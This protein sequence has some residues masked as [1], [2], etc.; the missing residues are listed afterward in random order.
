MVP[1]LF[2]H[3][4][5]EWTVVSGAP[6]SFGIAMLLGAAAIAWG[7]RWQ[8]SGRQNSYD[9]EAR[10][11]RATIT[12]LQASND[13]LSRKLADAEK[14]PGG[15]PVSA[16]SLKIPREPDG[17]YQFGRR[18]G[19]ASGAEIQ[20]GAGKAFFTRIRSQGNFNN[21]ND[22]EYRDFILRILSSQ[23]KTNAMA[24]GFSY[25]QIL[26]V[27]CQIVGRLPP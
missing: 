26:V 22:F 19:D 14:Q 7:F 5:A 11:L 9:A 21:E 2:D 24:S 18:V 3:M 20:E 23:A 17:I 16:L 27:T 8:Y 1:W 12:Q 10:A 25:Q 4:I 6:I 15:V 13:A